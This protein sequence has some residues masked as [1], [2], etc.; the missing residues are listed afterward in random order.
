MNKRRVLKRHGLWILVKNYTKR[1]PPKEKHW[2]Y[3]IC[4]VQLDES[5]YVMAV[6]QSFKE[7]QSCWE[8]TVSRYTQ[9]KCFIKY[10]F[11]DEWL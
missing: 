8:Q 6:F 5:E 10:P 11:R 3:A 2:N 9:N 7:A 4:A 1:R